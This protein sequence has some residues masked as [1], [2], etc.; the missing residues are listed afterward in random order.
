MLAGNPVTSA[1]GTIKFEDIVFSYPT[2]PAVN[3]FDGL[4]F[5]IPPGTNVAIV[6]SSGGG[7]S[8]I[9]KRLICFFSSFFFFSV[10]GF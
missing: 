7:K 10:G 1:R 8:T 4:N 5:E 2:R 9:S 3:I 6:G